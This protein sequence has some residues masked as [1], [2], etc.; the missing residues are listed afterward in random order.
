[1][2]RACIKH[3]IVDVLLRLRIDGAYKTDLYNELQEHTVVQ[4]MMREAE[5]YHKQHHIVSVALKMIVP[6]LPAVFKLA[7]LPRPITEPTTAEFLAEQVKD[8]FCSQLAITFGTSSSDY[9][10]NFN[11]FLVPGAPIHGA[12]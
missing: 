7:A 3:Q 8:P 4:R 11:G 9:S 2:R 6:G 5:E 1:M 12:I 10:Y